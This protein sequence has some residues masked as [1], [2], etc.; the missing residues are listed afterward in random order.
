[1]RSADFFLVY[2]NFN[3][4]LLFFFAV[5]L[6]KTG[7]SR[8]AL[9]CPTLDRGGRAGPPSLLPLADALD[10][11]SFVQAGALF[12]RWPAEIAFDRGAV[13]HMAYGS[14]DGAMV[15]LG[16]QA[17]LEM[18][19]TPGAFQNAVGRENCI[20]RNALTSIRSEHGHRLQQSVPNFRCDGTHNR[21]GAP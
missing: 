12:S 3:F 8:P 10:T 14:H 13:G 2:F 17:D 16:H 4:I 15:P 9:P 18:I 20:P 7:G 19:D 6:S 11:R 5:E 1:M 21:A